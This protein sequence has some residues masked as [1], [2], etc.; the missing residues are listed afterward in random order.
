MSDEGEDVSLEGEGG[1]EAMP[2]RRR[3]IK[4]QAETVAEWS[5]TKISARLSMII[6]A[7]VLMFMAWLAQDKVSHIDKRIDDV[8]AEQAKQG[9]AIS[10]IA[11]NQA[12]GKVE[13]DDQSKAIAEIKES[14][15]R[16][17]DKVTSGRKN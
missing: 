7:P 15:V 8:V 4:E 3:T 10:Q 11:I 1:G 12:Q 16:I 14:I 6:L 9:D 5:W 17:W 13:R 2:R